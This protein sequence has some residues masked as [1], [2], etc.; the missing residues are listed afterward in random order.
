MSND[1]WQRFVRIPSR[2]VF[3]GVCAGIAQYFDWNARVVRV[4]VV[5]LTIFVLGPMALVLYAA[6]WYLMPAAAPGR[7]PSPSR[8]GDAPPASSVPVR[9][10]DVKARFARLEQRLGSIEECVSSRDF[11]L[12]QEFRKLEG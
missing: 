6:L 9:M 5:L 11:D 7:L 4:A 2:G 10:A 12:R 8:D 3:A 1:F